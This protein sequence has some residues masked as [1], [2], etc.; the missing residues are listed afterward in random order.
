M[1][2]LNKKG[3]TLVELLAVIVVLALLM[4][5]AG[6][7]IIGIINKNRADSFVGTYKV[8]YNTLKMCAASEASETECLAMIDYD[9][10]QYGI[11]IVKGT[12]DYTVTVSA[13]TSGSFKNV[14]LVTH[15]GSD[16]KCV[17]DKIGVKG[18]DS[19]T[20]NSIT[21]IYKY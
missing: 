7:A 13:N 20:K 18:T 14:D 21:G 2:K 1:K 6:N 10:K 8:A 19:C 9:D 5:V 12:A 3:F 11:T 16:G 15:Y 17:T 4:V